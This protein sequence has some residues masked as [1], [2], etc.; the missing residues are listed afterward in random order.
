MDEAKTILLLYKKKQEE[1]KELQYKIAEIENSLTPTAK[2]D[3][4]PSGSLKTSP[5]E[6]AAIKLTTLKNIYKDKKITAELIRQNI[7]NLIEEMESTKYKELLYCRYLLLLTWREV[8]KR[9]Q[10]TRNSQNEYNIR[11]V[12]GYMHRNALKEFQTILNTT[13]DK[14]KDEIYDLARNQRRS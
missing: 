13:P 3:K 4:A 6:T 12:M 10:E 11:G 14:R 8:V 7:C 2:T 1:L 5:T 9:I